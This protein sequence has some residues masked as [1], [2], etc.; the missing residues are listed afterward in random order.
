MKL[1]ADSLTSF[2]LFFTASFCFS[3]SL[4]FESFQP[5]KFPQTLNIVINSY[6]FF[7]IFATSIVNESISLMEANCSSVA[8]DT[9]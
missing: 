1:A 7:G 8:A 2:S 5:F 3:F 9:L 4:G 6:N